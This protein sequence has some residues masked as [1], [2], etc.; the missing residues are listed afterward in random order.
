MT[1][2]DHRLVGRNTLA[3]L[4]EAVTALAAEGWEVENPEH[5]PTLGQVLAE[6]CKPGATMGVNL[7]IGVAMRKPVS[8]SEVKLRELVKAKDEAIAR[9]EQDYEDKIAALKEPPA[10]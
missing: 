9:L 5:G 10:E 3:D 6:R 8:D 7:A 2:Y 4:E 1:K